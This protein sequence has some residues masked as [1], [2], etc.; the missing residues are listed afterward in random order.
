M[1]NIVDEYS[2]DIEQATQFSEVRDLIGI[3]RGACGAGVPDL[4]AFDAILRGGLAERTMLLTATS[5]SLVYERVGRSVVLLFGHDPTGKMTVAISNEGARA[6]WERYRRAAETGKPVFAVQHQIGL[7]VV[8]AHERL[9]L[10]VATPQGRKLIVYVRARRDNADL[11]RAVFN[12]STDGIMVIAA[13]RDTA[14]KIVDFRIVAANREIAR[15]HASEPDGLTG[16]LLCEAYPEA[17]GMGLVELYGTAIERDAPAIHEISFERAGNMECRELRLMPLGDG[18]VVTSVD[19]GPR[20]A[21]ARAVKEQQDEAIAAN[22]RLRRQA[23]KLFAANRSLKEKTLE[24]G[25]EIARNRALEAELTRLAHIDRLTGLP[26]RARFEDLVE[27]ALR[28]AGDQGRTAALCIFD[29]DHFKEIND[30]L[31]HSAGDL[32]LREAARRLAGTLGERDVAGRLGGDEFAVLIG[33]PADPADVSGKVSRLVEEMARPCAAGPQDLPMGVSAGVAVFPDHGRKPGELFAHADIALYRG[34]RSGRGTAVLFQP[35]MRGSLDRRVKLLERFRRALDEGEIVAH[36]QPIVALAPRSL[37]GFEA[38]ARWRHPERGLLPAARFLGALE[39]PGLANALCWTMIDRVTSDF[40]LWGRRG[41]AVAL[42][43][44]AFDLRQRDFTTEV[45]ARLA[46]GGMRCDQLVIEVTEAAIISRDAGRVVATVEEARKAGLRVAL[47]DFGPGLASLAPLRDTAVDFL[48][49]DR[50][51]VRNLESD[52]KSLDLVAAIA[53]LARTMG[54]SIILEGVE[55]RAQL[56]FAQTL[57]CD[58]VQGYLVAKPMPSE[59]VGRFIARFA[60]GVADPLGHPS[61]VMP[62]A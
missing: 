39:E 17:R 6:F 30:S 60:D 47:D 9:I 44:T 59:Q 34:K 56:D 19:L 23:A 27:Q 26:N 40:S 37:V 43:V 50:S 33:D 46:A 8:G 38:L 18:L 32:V 45:V 14:G 15:R 10:P 48:K 22:R 31:G 52:A 36:Y 57:P 62:A 41:L 58:A 53:S 49:I 4:Q 1:V 12:G 16:R 24:L 13:V 5:D 2:D 42:N 35:F 11:L 29:I 54:L 51:F 28:T 25:A 21:A 20:R 3:W 7:G 61:A 55:T